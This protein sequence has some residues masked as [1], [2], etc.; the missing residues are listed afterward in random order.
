MIL[1]LLAGLSTGLGDDFER[2][3]ALA[4]GGRWDE[5]R[6]AFLEGQRKAPRD[7]RFPLE[8]AGIAYRNQDLP[9]ARRLPPAG[10]PPRPARPLWQ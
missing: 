8:L 1:L 10:S 6:T 2:G 7:K 5:A 3:I 4:R 9:A